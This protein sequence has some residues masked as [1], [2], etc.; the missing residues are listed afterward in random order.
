V[1]DSGSIATLPTKSRSLT[2]QK[3]RKNL[4]EA[5]FGVLSGVGNML[6][7]LFMNNKL[8]PLFF[9]IR[10]DAALHNCRIISFRV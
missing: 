8:F 9:R 10:L 3:I 1:N 5:P 4:E 7:L 2:V 6:I